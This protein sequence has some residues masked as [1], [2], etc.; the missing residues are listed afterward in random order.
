[1]ME[2]PPLALEVIDGEVHPVEAPPCGHQMGI[3]ERAVYLRCDLPKGHSPEDKHRQVLDIGHAWIGR[4]CDGS[5]SEPCFGW[6][7]GLIEN[8]RLQGLTV[9]TGWE[10]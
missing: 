1:M 7:M 5:C 4:W 10:P 2:L 8:L 3:P 9:N 6:G